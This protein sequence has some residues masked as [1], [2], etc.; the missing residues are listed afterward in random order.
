V[1]AV[2][3][4]PSLFKRQL[5]VDKKMQFAIIVYSMLVAL[6][7]ILFMAAFILILQNAATN[8]DGSPQSQIRYF[9]LLFGLWLGAMVILTFLGVYVTNK[10]AGPIYRLRKNMQQVAAG[11]A[12]ENVVFRKDDHFLD[13]ADDY[14]QVLERLRKAEGK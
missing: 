10:T 6:T 1:T 13:V 5:L 2:R 7:T 11:G 12:I 14:N 9:L 3:N 4:R 8:L